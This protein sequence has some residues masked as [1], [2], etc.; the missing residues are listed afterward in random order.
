MLLEGYKEKLFKL[1]PKLKYSYKEQSENVVLN[2]IR[3]MTKDVGLSMERTKKSINLG[4]SY[5]TGYL[6]SIT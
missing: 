4:S 2:S 3:T 1:F 6:Y 5:R